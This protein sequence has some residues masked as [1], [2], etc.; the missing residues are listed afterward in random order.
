MIKTRHNYPTDFGVTFLIDSVI[1]EERLYEYIM[2]NME[3]KD[4][5]VSIAPVLRYL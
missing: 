1:Q 5:S 4:F 3:Q 2:N